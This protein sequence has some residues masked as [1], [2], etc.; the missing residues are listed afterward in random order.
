MSSGQELTR[1]KDGGQRIVEPAA[2][3]TGVGI[4]RAAEDKALLVCRHKK[5]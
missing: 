2:T 1:K 3:A 4:W 5:V